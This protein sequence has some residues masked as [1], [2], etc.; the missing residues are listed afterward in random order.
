MPAG[1]EDPAGISLPA[2]CGGRGKMTISG[3]AVVAATRGLAVDGDESGLSGQASRTQAVNASENSK[4][5]I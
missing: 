4:G 1:S 3:A 2:S 5:L